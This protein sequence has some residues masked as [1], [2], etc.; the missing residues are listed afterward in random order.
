MMAAIWPAEKSMDGMSRL[1]DIESS[2]RRTSA[3]SPESGSWYTSVTG[4]GGRW[5]MRRYV[6][7][8]WSRNT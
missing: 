6:A 4:G 5:R 7:P 3:R 2:L 1:P 8:T